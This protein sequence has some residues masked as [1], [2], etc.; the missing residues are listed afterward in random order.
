MINNAPFQQ[1]QS[2][3]GCPKK[4]YTAQ[5]HYKIQTTNDKT[6]KQRQIDR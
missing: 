3:T 5:N 6:M 1:G 2:Y 4:K